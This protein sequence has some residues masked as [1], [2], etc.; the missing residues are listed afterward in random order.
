MLAFVLRLVEKALERD[1]FLT[2][3]HNLIPV[4]AFPRVQVADFSSR[5]PLNI[6][7]IAAQEALEFGI[8]DSV[9]EKR[10]RMETDI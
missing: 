5:V 6:G 8:V 4:I 10:P 1:Y 3:K 9:L 2:G 7:I